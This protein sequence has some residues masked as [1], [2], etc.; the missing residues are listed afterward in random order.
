MTEKAIYVLTHSSLDLVS[1]LNQFER[2]RDRY[3]V[4][5]LISST[6][7]NLQFLQ[8]AGLP[9]AALRFMRFESRLNDGKR[10]LARLVRDLRAEKRMLDEAA[11]EIRANPANEL[12]LHSY[13]DPHFGYLA[14]RVAPTNPVTLINILDVERERLSMRELLTLKGIK[15][16]VQREL[17]NLIF[18]RLYE[19]RGTASYPML[20]LDLQRVR[21]RREPKSA[22]GTVQTLAKY[23]YRIPAGARTAFVLYADSFGVSEVRH[24]EAYRAVLDRLTAAGWR[25]FVKLHPQSSQPEF[26]QAYAVDYVPKFV[27]FELVDLGGVSLVV[28]LWGASLLCTGGVPTVS[29]LPLLYDAGS[30]HYRGAMPQL[31]QNPAIRFVGSAAELDALVGELE[32]PARAS[33]AGLSGVD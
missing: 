6:P 13:D 5:I 21:L 14:S 23:R 31:L 8:H 27:P 19:L 24:V 26:L 32:A 28:G 17:M 12:I 18:G 15:N 33:S 30:D 10:S 20:V 2:H 16:L 25:V 7:E 11:A 3:R 1:T 22:G 4:S 29:I 9:A